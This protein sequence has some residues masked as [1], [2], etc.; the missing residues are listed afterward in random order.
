MKKQA[1][2]AQES[3]LENLKRRLTPGRCGQRPG[4]SR[5]IR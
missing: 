2:R 5:A 3:E 4:V 1:C